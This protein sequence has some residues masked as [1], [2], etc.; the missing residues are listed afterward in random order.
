MYYNRYITN[1]S[2]LVQLI[3]KI[4]SE[5]ILHDDMTITTEFNFT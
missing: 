2:V 3:I 4:T 5:D 1:I